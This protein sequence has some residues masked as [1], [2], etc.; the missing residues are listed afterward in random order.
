MP[1]SNTPFSA[2]KTASQQTPL[3]VD[4]LF[5]AMRSG[6]S[7][8]YD[9]RN[10]NFDP[11]N[12]YRKDDSSSL[13]RFTIEQ[14][15]QET[16]DPD[17][18]TYIYDTIE[19]LE[20]MMSGEQRLIYDS[21]IKNVKDTLIYDCS[22]HL[23]GTGSPGGNRAHHSVIN[24]PAGTGKSLILLALALRTNIIMGRST[25]AL[26]FSP[27]YGGVSAIYDKFREICDAL[28][29]SEAKTARAI[30]VLKS[31]VNIH[32]T[33]SFYASGA[34]AFGAY[35]EEVL[36]K[37]IKNI[38]RNQ[39]YPGVINHII[40]LRECKLIGLDECFFSTVKRKK[41]ILEFLEKGIIKNNL[42]MNSFNQKYSRDF[43]NHLK[44]SKNIVYCGDTCQLSIGV[45]RSTIYNRG[46]Q[47][48]PLWYLEQPIFNLHSTMIDNIDDYKCYSLTKS[49]RFNQENDKELV[50]LIENIRVP[51]YE[52]EPGY[53]EYAERIKLLVNYMHSQKMIH[54]KAT[55][56]KTIQITSGFHNSGKDTRIVTEIHRTKA[57]LNNIDDDPRLRINM[58]PPIHCYNPI[59]IPTEGEDIPISEFLKTDEFKELTPEKKKWLKDIMKNEF[60]TGT[61]AHKF[62]GD[63]YPKELAFD[64]DISKEEYTKHI[65]IGDLVRITYPV[66]ARVNDNESE[67]TSLHRICEDGKTE[68]LP[69]NFKLNTGDYARAVSYTKE[70]GLVIIFN[71][72]ESEQYY[73]VYPSIKPREIEIAFG[74]ETIKTK[75]LIIAIKHGSYLKSE[76]YDTP[77]DERR[78]KLSVKC[79]P[80]SKSAASTIHSLQGKSFDRGVQVG[81]YMTS[82][83][84]RNDL[85]EFI[86]DRTGEF[87]GSRRMF[88]YVAITRS[89]FPSTNF[90][91]FTEANTK[92]ELIKLILSGK[93]PSSY[94]ELNK[95]LGI[96]NN[97]IEK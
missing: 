91:L 45:E 21:I 79:V 52:E 43:L 39:N 26:L 23:W 48:K 44:F 32:V 37:L 49:H 27:S 84:R 85:G 40:A 22:P 77:I 71:D 25:G 63:I 75:N 54:Y 81:Y 9:L 2:S 24:A 56:K 5:E 64:N 10:V 60:K 76:F 97:S 16:Q 70:E 73:N 94:K 61:M 66:R 34:R 11:S 41:A 57:E 7:T 29:Y 18:R 96:F 1:R 4:G 65:C 46:E 82:R 89:R 31:F 28:E 80:V 30:A 42:N 14:L 47:G 17:C 95:F 59:I 67:I 3:N 55:P 19:K 62:V 87:K 38:N 12:H 58:D 8:E 86:D 53:D 33:N 35:N 88:L 6:S 83:I 90:C 69:K 36:G 15:E 93:R 50:T 51:Y 68:L 74:N 92:S 13:T 20:S 72:K 78:W